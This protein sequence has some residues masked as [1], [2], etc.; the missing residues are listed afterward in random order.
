VVTKITAFT[1]CQV[2]HRA[3]SPEWMDRDRLPKLPAASSSHGESGHV[4]VNVHGGLDVLLIED[5][6]DTSM[7]RIVDDGLVVFADSAGVE[8]LVKCV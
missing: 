4:S 2:P 3:R 1:Y 8:L 5:T 7:V 6:E